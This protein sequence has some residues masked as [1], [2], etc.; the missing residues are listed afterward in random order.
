M[1]AAFRNSYSGPTDAGEG[2]CTA[3]LRLRRFT[4]NDLPLLDR[5]NSDIEVMRYLGGT[6]T[7][8]A[9]R[10]VL[11]DR[12]LRYYDEHPGLGVWASLLRESQECIGFHLLNHVQGETLIQVGYRLF[13]QFWGQGY[14]TE[15]SLALLHYGFAHKR[16][17][18]LTANAHLDN[19][20]SQ[21]VLL[22]CGLRRKGERT[23]AHPA[24]AAY[25]NVAYFERDAAGWLAEYDAT[26]NKISAEHRVGIR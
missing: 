4:P 18:T 14:A 5:L 21:R 2:L 7:L 10:V 16:L 8:D 20:A 19:H 13:P 23:F 9:T 3:R 11:H 15:M 25:A 17:P 24:Y 26:N 12:I 22:K 1:T 6:A